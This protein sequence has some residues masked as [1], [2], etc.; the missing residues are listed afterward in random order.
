M[1]V[2]VKDL[3]TI[4]TSD[5]SFNSYA[6]SLCTS[7]HKLSSLS[8]S[9]ISHLPMESW[10]ISKEK[11]TTIWDVG[12]NQTGYTPWFS[13]RLDVDLASVSMLLGEPH[14]RSEPMI[15]IVRNTARTGS[16]TFSRL[17]GENMWW[18]AGSAGRAPRPHLL[19]SIAVWASFED[20]ETSGGP[21]QSPCAE[22]N[23]LAEEVSRGNLM[24]LFVRESLLTDP[25]SLP[26]TWG[27]IIKL[28]SEQCNSPMYMRPTSKF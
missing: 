16:T 21:A 24:I 15:Y 26:L 7:S 12:A 3:S 2:K 14:S 5:G 28:P 25:F 6:C 18:A 10:L 11:N 17:R 20:F 23:L 27:V 9:V 22:T 13:M 8:L 1:R 19:V 4:Y